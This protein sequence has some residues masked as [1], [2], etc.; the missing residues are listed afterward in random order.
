LKATDVAGRHFAFKYKLALGISA[1]IL[2]LLAG[3]FLLIE[4]FLRFYVTA[5]TEEDLF[6]T[7]ALVSR[8]LE[9]RRARLHE[10]GTA[11]AGDALTRTL[12]TDRTLDRP[13]RD[14][15]VDGEILPSYPQLMVMAVLDANGSTRALSDA[16]RPLE[17]PLR[18]LAA[19]RRALEGEPGLGFIRDGDGIVQT[20]SVPVRIGPQAAREVIGAV[21]V[22]RRWSMGELETIRRMSRAEVAFYD[23]DGIFLASGPPF[24]GAN[25]GSAWP[26][27]GPLPYG[28]TA[29]VTAGAERFIVVKS[30]EPGD[31][32][33][34]YLVAR[35]LDRQLDFMGRIRR[36]LLELGL[37][38]ILVGCA[39][40]LLLALGISR[41]IRRLQEALRRVSRGDFSEPVQVRSRDEFA[42]LADAFNRMQAGLIERESMRRAL[43]MA[44]EVQRNLLPTE[45]PRVPGLDAAGASL[46]CQAI[47][48]DYYDYL[49]VPGGRPVLRVVLADVC[50]HGTAAALLMASSR[51]LLRSRALQPGPLT[52]VATDVNRELARDVRDSGRFV[53]MLLVE[54]DVAAGELRWVRAGHDPALLFHPGSETFEHLHASGLPLGVEEDQRYALGT[55]PGLAEGHI[56]VLGTDGLWEARDASGAMYGKGRLLSTLRRHA[57]RPAASIV[58]AVLDDLRAFK[59]AGDLE[60]DATLVVVKRVPAPQGHGLR[61]PDGG[62][63]LPGDGGVP[64]RVTEWGGGAPPVLAVHGLTANG[65]CWD[66]I[67]DALGPAHRF[68]AVD[69]RGR[70]QSGRP[71][72]GYSVA[73]HVRDLIEVLDGLGLARAVL[74]GHSLGAFIALATAAEHPDR[75]E[76]LVLVDGG[77]DLA[78]EHMERVLG[79]IRP[80][81]ARLGTVFASVDD[82]LGR[83]RA[84]PYLQPWSEAVERYCRYEI[85]PAPGGVRVNI[86]PAHI[87]EEGAH[88]RA[89]R[90][91]SFYPRVR[92]PV[93]ILRATE[94][95]LQPDDVLLPAE[96]IQRMRRALP[97]AQHVDVTGAD[98]YGIVFK[99]HPGR[100]HALREFLRPG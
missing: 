43:L 76:R 29:V 17:A 68:L 36:W 10:L 14:D 28:R 23:P 65:R 67:A 25:G 48:G 93:L 24:T 99:P 42:E 89:L 11:L 38:G 92:C 55:R 66:T 15:L 52:D 63:C 6:T 60:D 51:A 74:M 81:L 91:E 12:L 35:S 94:G 21:V 18:A 80:A 100:D 71:P 54:V 47:G 62:R 69:L 41:P 90:C 5:E 79:A 64:I 85:E 87:A 40:S 70:G 7:R 56:L 78:P 57:E 2:V 26:Q 97:S 83:M 22:G 96:A 72:A 95:L 39:V 4:S 98:H 61:V 59:G 9:E 75:V 86:D 49:A 58:Q 77:A 37:G 82:Y 88:L 1:V 84:A 34:P 13:T 19:A 16:A 50:G 30:M 73:A 3:V 8:L 32:S 53:T 33:A 44:E 45:A 46:Y 31:V 20:A 27:L